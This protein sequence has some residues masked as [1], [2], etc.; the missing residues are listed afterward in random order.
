MS[1]ITLK[2]GPKPFTILATHAGSTTEIAITGMTIDGVSGTLGYYTVKQ[3]WKGKIY[4]ADVAAKDESLAFIEISKNLS[5]TPL[6]W[7]KTKTIYVPSPGHVG[8]SWRYP[9]I[10]E[11]Y[12]DDIGIRVTFQQTS[13]A[14]ID[15][16]MHGEVSPL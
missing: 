14:R 1:D 13:G 12:E 5:S 15:V 2:P 4:E 16:S 7:L 10:V 6:K 3:G 9:V 11:A 8:R